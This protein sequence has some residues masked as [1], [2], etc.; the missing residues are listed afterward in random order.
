MLPMLNVA[1]SFDRAAGYFRSASLAAAAAGLERFVLDGGQIRLLV[2]HELT[3]QDRD[4]VLRGLDLRESVSAAVTREP[5]SADDGA[6]SDALELLCTLVA[7]EQLDVKVAVATDPDSGE[8]LRADQARALYHSKFGVFTDRCDP[9]CQVAFEG[10][11]N[12]TPSGWLSNRE[13]FSTFRS[14]EPGDWERHGR[15]VAEDFE[16]HWDG[17]PDPGWAIVDLPQAAKDRLLSKAST[18]RVTQGLEGQGRTGDIGRILE[19][20]R[21]ARGDQGA[22]DVD[23]FAAIDEMLAAPATTSG[24]GVA[25]STVTPWL[26]QQ[27]V[28]RKVVQAW[29]CSRMFA[30]E[31]GL[32]KTI[33]VGLVLRELLVSD[34]ARRLLLLVPAA[35]QGQWQTE[36]WE[37][38]TL[39]VPS[40][41]GGV[42]RWP[43]GSVPEGMEKRPW[44]GNRWDAA[45]VMLAS[46][47]LA[48]RDDH[49]RHLI[50]RQWD[51]VVVDE[52]HHARR[53]GLK[54][55]R[56][57]P[58]ALLQL[59]RRMRDADCWQG[60]LLATATPMQM[61]AHEA[62][63]L[64]ALLGLPGRADEEDLEQQSWA[65]AGAQ[66]FV[67]YYEQLNVEEPGR[68]NWKLLSD[69]AASHF[70]RWPAYDPHLETALEEHLTRREVSSVQALPDAMSTSRYRRL[71]TE[72]L[73]W[74]DL[75][76]REHTPM[77]ALVYRNTRHLLRAYLDAGLLAEGT[78]I[79]RRDVQEKVVKFTEVEQ[80]LYDRIETWISE[81][82]SEVAAA[83][84]RGDRKAKAAGFIMTVY[85]RRLT[86]S[87]A[88]IENSLRK[89]RD[90][91]R[92]SQGGLL[93]L[94]ALLEE[95]DR[96][97]TSDT[98]DLESLDAALDPDDAAGSVGAAVGAVGD[99]LEMVEQFLSDL[100]LR[101]NFDSK[102]GALIDDLKVEL[103]QPKPDGGAR[104]AIVF[105][106][107]TDTM[108]EL[109]G[110]LAVNW[111][112][113]VCCY[114]GRGGELHDQVSGTW[115]RLTKQQLKEQFRDGAFRLLIG[116][117]A[118]SEG[119]NLQTCELLYNLDLP[120]NFM[121]VEQ[122]IGRVDRIGG[123]PTVHIR[124]L[125]IAGTVEERVYSGIKEDFGNFEHVVGAAQPVLAQ[126]EEAIREA[127]MATGP[128][129]D[130]LL[131]ARAQGLID[132]ANAATS[133][134]V[135][136]DTFQQPTDTP[137]TVD[138]WAPAA[139]LEGEEAEWLTRLEG[140]LTS[141]EVLGARFS[142]AGG[143]CWSYTDEDGL[144]WTVTFHRQVADDSAGTV[145]LFVWGHPAFDMLRQA[146]ARSAHIANKAAGVTE[147]VARG[148]VSPQ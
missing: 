139:P 40:L 55:G 15:D 147:R 105:T 89:R 53:R 28:A 119:L 50:D 140:T 144:E 42:L 127:A 35:V 71:S 21:A 36:L 106:Q 102:M 47:H 91:L 138:Q 9:P 90:K 39:A 146:R 57:D 65:D 133:A 45:D 70:A 92:E 44:S 141:H 120:W 30:D 122:R 103:G 64:L 118:M 142:S 107:F 83:A 94:A 104:Q 123:H 110:E 19:R 99:E 126:T 2:N 49:Q 116:T 130:E 114:S 26:H 23:P 109:K 41:E 143:G 56:D 121:R 72:T 77:R 131:A 78:T 38:F 17:D 148:S 115:K 79:P 69:L 59:L 29:P 12:E 61:A 7:M 11:N 51:I 84:A 117:D 34:R 13:S 10:S 6:A 80:E 124:N 8:P 14:W 5:L 33:E 108:D 88:A 74:V 46:S 112:G 75:W 58:N 111:P 18:D 95:D 4:A 22:D 54:A 134:P 137:A 1:A 136:L 32:G 101:P 16:A 76:L 67:D 48:R 87:F 132:N 66:G 20:I 25:T 62:Y 96:T 125:L 3:D 98:P 97:A 100:E 37:K 145:G 31:V 63:D 129:R 43:E 52:A 135:N 86:S 81:R 68:R 82:Y 93:S 60:L 27:D 128:D 73:P 85:R 113:Q 24:V